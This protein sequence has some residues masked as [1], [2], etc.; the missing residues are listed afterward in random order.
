MKM[1][2]V[3]LFLVS[4]L[5]GG[6]FS[7][8]YAE[9]VSEKYYTQPYWIYQIEIEY[10]GDKQFYVFWDGKRV[11]ALTPDERLNT[12]KIK[13]HATSNETTLQISDSDDANNLSADVRI[14][15]VV[16]IRP[17]SNEEIKIAKS[18]SIEDPRDKKILELESR[19]MALEN[20]KFNLEKEVTRL[21]GIVETL[22]DRIKN[23]TDEFFVTIQ[24][25]LNWFQDQIRN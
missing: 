2:L 20:E 1:I 16:E 11:N 24:N 21:N 17:M 22:Q 18:Q 6:T 14:L 19:I 5:V 3:Y 12:S 15:D 25:Q 4:I 8:I 23:L 10:S 7:P 13:I 9:S